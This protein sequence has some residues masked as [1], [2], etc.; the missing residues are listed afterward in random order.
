MRLSNCPKTL[1]VNQFIYLHPC[2]SKGYYYRGYSSHLH[3]PHTL[4]TK[5][6]GSTPSS[7]HS[8][9]FGSGCIPPLK[10]REEGYTFCMKM[11]NLAPMKTCTSSG[12]YWWNQIQLLCHPKNK[13]YERNGT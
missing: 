9:S 11:S 5:W 2:L 12:L 6:G 1:K 8:R 13:G 7:L 4:F 3:E 10:T